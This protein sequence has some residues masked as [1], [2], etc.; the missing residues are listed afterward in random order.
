MSSELRVNYQA[1]EAGASDL[2]V[3]AAELERK[4]NDMARRMEARR[5]E[6]SG[7]DAEAFEAC[8]IEWNNGMAQ[9]NQAL[10]GIGQAVRLSN[11][12]YQATEANNARR[13][14]W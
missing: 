12:Q 7:R 5:S 3:A 11:E 1:L 9:M 6:W 13:F 8:R 2:T 14:A 4:I 10:Q